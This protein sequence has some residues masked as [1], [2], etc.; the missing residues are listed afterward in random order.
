MDKSIMGTLEER[1]CAALADFYLGQVAPNDATAQPLNLTSLDDLYE[2]LLLDSQVGQ[3]PQTSSVAEGL[4]CLQQYV[5]AIYS[6]LESGHNAAFSRDELEAWHQYYSNISD[7]AGYE[8]LREYPENWINPTLRLHKSES[9]IDLENNLSQGGLNEATVQTALFEHLKQFEEV[10]N[11]DLI[12]GYIDSVDGT[13]TGKGQNFKN[14]DYYFIG[15]QRVQPFGY[16]WRKAHVEISD[17]S[18]FLDPAAWTEWKTVELPASPKRLAIQ[19]V[20]FAGRLMMVQVEVTEIKQQEIEFGDSV[21]TI[22]GGWEFDITLSYLAMN[23]TWTTPMS[24]AKP[25]RGLRDYLSGTPARLVAVNYVGAKVSDDQLAVCFALKA[26]ASSDPTD[27]LFASVN[28]LFEPLEPDEA[29]L[30]KLAETGF[31]DATQLQHHVLA[32]GIVTPD[33]IPK[34]SKQASGSQFLDLRPLSVTGLPW[35]R[36]NSLFGPTLV[37]LAS[38]SIDE[39]LSLT[40]QN[41]LEPQPEN[42]TPATAPIDFNSAH[43]YF[44]WELFFH[45]P[46][47]VAHRLCEE[48]NFLESQRWY[49][50]IFNPHIRTP[51]SGASHPTDRYWLCRPLLEPGQIGFEAKGLVDPDAIA[52]ANRIHY[53][54][55]IFMS[56]VRCIIAHADSYY[57]RLTRD[58]LVAAKQQYVR[59]LSLMGPA[60]KSKAMSHWA[61]QSAED[62][63]KPLPAQSPS[64]LNAF[65]ASLPVDVA[66]LPTRVVGAPDF[67]ILGLDVF[68]P[69]TNDHLLN[70]W[71][72]LDEC[73]WNMRHNLTIDGKVMNLAL[74]APATDPLDLMRAQ[75]GGASGAMRNAGGW[76]TIPHYRFRPL[77]STAQNA[78]QTLIGFGREVRQL[79]ELRDRGQLEELQQSQVIAVGAHAKTIQEETISQ[80]EASLRS[81]EHSQLMVEERARHYK[82]V[83]ENKLLGVEI[84]GDV[85]SLKGKLTGAAAAVPLIAGSSMKALP[86]LFGFVNDLGSWGE[87]L[88]AT[89]GVAGLVSGVEYATGEALQRTA[90]YQRRDEEWAFAQRQAESEE[91]VLQE[92]IFAQ[93]HT[94]NAAK[95]SLAQ[96]QKAN[97]QAQEIYAFY[98]T[99]ATNVEL[100]RW[101]LGQMA[102]L[103]FQAYDA[104]VG[105]CLNAE[106]SFQYEMGDF[107]TQVIR[108]NVWMDHR[109]GLSAG[110]SMSLDLLRLERMYLERAERR[111]ELTK[112]ISL[113]QFFEQGEFTLVKNWDDVIEELK[114]GKLDFEFSQR[115]F[116]SDYPGHFCRQIVAV[117]ITLPAVLHAYQDVHA[118]LTQTG[119]TTVHKADVDALDYLY[120]EGE[121]IPPRGIFLNPRVNQQV[122]MSQGVD[123]YGLHQMMFGDERYLPFEG[124][125]AVSRWRLEFPRPKSPRQTKLIDTLTDIIVHV[126]YLAKIGGTAYTAAVVERLG[127]DDGAA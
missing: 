12:A 94:L 111:L 19:P 26:S 125:G 3:E 42:E 32:T 31:A 16:F 56:Y 114:A 109:H 2:Y 18:T 46:F 11:L 93:Q 34:I 7:W 104:V 63:L 55:A 91:R 119:S 10:C 24:L 50:Y 1:R 105:L 35:V 30:I 53:R 65:A 103:Y 90:F 74:Y 27:Y 49:H 78:V 22:G 45:L 99:R 39:V 13:G 72:Y 84:A 88:H 79:M 123:D 83:R 92:Q 110:E 21:I 77:L 89:S 4:A 76:K 37:A 9:F 64:S 112:T 60:P 102:T 85:L 124:T 71:K 6:G 52:F 127:D 8:M 118:T 68:R 58:G 38:I 51:R 86:K 80:I 36:L 117:S 54:K 44:Y 43:G 41:T 97:D 70:T 81:L 14:A 96:I 15:Q 5:G 69:Y 67:E 121:G 33:N 62:I 108:P 115:M 57:R 98:K 87:L 75:A 40:T 113:R 82:G 28:A 23:G 59:A 20:F 101:L 120:G 122:G 100:Y 116:D 66:N 73:L 48:R 107:D 29:A 47:L 126:R 17:N 25:W 61:P 95:A 106:A